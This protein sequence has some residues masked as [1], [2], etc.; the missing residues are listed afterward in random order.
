MGATVT[1]TFIERVPQSFQDL[2][3]EWWQH[4]HQGGTNVLGRTVSGSILSKPP[5]Q[6]DDFRRVIHCVW[7]WK[8]G[9]IKDLWC[10]HYSDEWSELQERL[11]LEGKPW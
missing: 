11:K 4:K 2:H 5:E 8:A 3:R 7:C 10:E 9:A 1:R 6:P